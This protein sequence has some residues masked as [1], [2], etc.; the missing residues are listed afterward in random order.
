M[1]GSILAGTAKHT[2]TSME[3]HLEIEADHDAETIKAIVAQAEQMCFVM[4]A[5]EQQH[6]VTRRSSLNGSRL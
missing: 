5:I 3:T 4:D 1:A 2:L 6:E